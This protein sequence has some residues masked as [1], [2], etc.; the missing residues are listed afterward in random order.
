M[1][2]KVGRRRRLAFVF[3]EMREGFEGE[4]SQVQSGG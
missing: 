1:A 4:A 3:S 2:L